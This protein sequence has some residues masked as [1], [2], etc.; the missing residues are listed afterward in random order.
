MGAMRVLMSVMRIIMGTRRIFTGA[1]RVLMGAMKILMGVMKAQGSATF[2][3]VT[4][5]HS[6]RE[7]RVPVWFSTRGN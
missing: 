4:M 3:N 5:A 2:A 7:V 1:M 6:L